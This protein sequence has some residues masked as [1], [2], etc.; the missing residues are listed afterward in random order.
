[1]I[2]VWCKDTAFLSIITIHKIS[3]N[4]Q[5]CQFLLV[6]GGSLEIKK[7]RLANPQFAVKAIPAFNYFI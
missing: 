7:W 2:D 6:A 5:N 3:Q 1:M 4:V